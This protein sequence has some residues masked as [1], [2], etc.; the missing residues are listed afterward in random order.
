[1]K[2]K[3]ANQDILEYAKPKNVI[4]NGKTTVTT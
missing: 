3:F 2:N 4:A 1:M